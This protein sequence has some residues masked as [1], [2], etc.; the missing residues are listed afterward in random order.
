M[1]SQRRMAKKPKSMRTSV[2]LSED[3]HKR[4]L[5]HPVWVNW[6]AVASEAFERKLAE[7]RPEGGESSE[8]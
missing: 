1:A 7:Y 4:M 2:S 6:S 8:K 5:D 3:L